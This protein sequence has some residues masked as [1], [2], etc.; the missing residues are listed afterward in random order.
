MKWR[1]GKLNCKQNTEANAFHYSLIYSSSN[2]ITQ[3]ILSPHSVKWNLSLPQRQCLLTRSSSHI[4]FNCSKQKV[5][6]HLMKF[7]S[8]NMLSCEYL[9]FLGDKKIEARTIQTVAFFRYVLPFFLAVF[10]NLWKSVTSLFFFQEPYKSITLFSLVHS[11]NDKRRRLPPNHFW[12]NE[13]FL[14]FSFQQG[15]H[16]LKCQFHDIFY[17]KLLFR[18]LGIWH[19]EI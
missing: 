8:K 13:F 2:Y 1:N 17:C 18:H 5:D 6:L 9:F 4:L 16:R 19:S 15:C 14:L 3:G 12:N 10:Q 11:K 7:C